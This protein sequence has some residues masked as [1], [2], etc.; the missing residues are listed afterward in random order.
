MKAG[1]PDSARASVRIVH[2]YAWLW[3][4]LESEP[5]FVLRTMFGTKAVYLGG[6]MV[7]CFS[8]KEEPWRGLLIC[9]DRAHHAS[10]VKQFPV[11]VPHPI[12]PKWLYLPEAVPSFEAMA[13]RM[14][15]LVRARDPRIGIEPNPASSRHRRRAAKLERTVSKAHPNR[16][17]QGG[18]KRPLKRAKRR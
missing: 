10:L 13:S 8:A 2:P 17:A 5:S 12:L 18:R 14:V 1:R 11:L 4:P 9:T 6:R 7:L 16:T 15:A 3:E